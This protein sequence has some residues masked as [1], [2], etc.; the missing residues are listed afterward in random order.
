MNDHSSNQQT[1]KK[2]GHGKSVLTA[3][4]TV[5]AM[6]MAFLGLTQAALAAEVGGAETVPT[7]YAAQTQASAGQTASAS[8][9]QTANYT[10]V[11][12]DLEY[13]RD[14]KPAAGHL[15][16]EEAA[17]VGAQGLQTAFGVDL[18]G[19]VLEMAY[20]PAHDGYRANWE[21]IWWP[22]GKKEDGAL[23]VHSYSF[24]V[25]AVSGALSTVGHGRVL[26]ETADAGFDAG[27]QQNAAAYEAAAKEWAE[28]LA[29]VPS[30]VLTVNYAGQGATNNDPD[31]SFLVT[32]LNGERAR[33]I[34]SRYD[35]ALLGVTY[36]AGMQDLD[37]AGQ[38]AEEFAAR[39]QAYFEAH[40]EA[41]TYGE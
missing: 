35:K 36:E 5:G 23:Y 26:D 25:D 31:I 7:S 17:A 33:V 22:D 30:G 15:S 21:G 9:E 1:R 8:G 12:N 32:G 40:P 37:A 10:L 29:L 38:N 11:D 41:T 16:R 4:V 3:A 27:L 2:Q 19:A 39:A 14:K 28:K 13:Y 20:N 6:T 34:L 24:T 18:D